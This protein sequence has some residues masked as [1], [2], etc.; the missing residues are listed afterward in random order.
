VLVASDFA[1]GAEAGVSS[2]PCSVSILNGLKAVPLGDLDVVVLEPWSCDDCYG[3]E[4]T[5]GGQPVGYYQGGVLRVADFFS[6]GETVFAHQRVWVLSKDSFIYEERAFRRLGHVYM[7]YQEGREAP[8]RSILGGRYLVCN[9][10][11]ISTEPL[12]CT[13][14]EEDEGEEYMGEPFDAVRAGRN[15]ISLFEGKEAPVGEP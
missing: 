6:F 7:T 10:H 14:E 8:V 9:G 11:V 12:E 5:D 15:I 2:P 13:V 1:F 4:S 3:L